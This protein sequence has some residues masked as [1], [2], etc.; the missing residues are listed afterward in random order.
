MKI[1]QIKI[2]P[3][4]YAPFNLAQGYRVGDLLFIS[5]QTA[6]DDNGQLIGI[7]DFDVQAQKAFENLEKVLKAGGSSLKNVV[8]ATILLRDMSN[9]NKI[10]KLREKYFTKPY[11]A[12]TICEVSSLFSSEA[13]IEIEAIA[14]ADDAA[15]WER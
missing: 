1:S 8:K 2:T 15:E 14:V 13:L 3:D 11:P 7:G 6:I 5:G 10:V 4:T 9:F 12:D